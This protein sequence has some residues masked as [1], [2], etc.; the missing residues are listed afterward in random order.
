MTEIAPGTNRAFSFTVPT[1]HPDNVW[2]LWTTPD[3][4]EQWD[5]GLK[6]A[7]LDGPMSLGSV[8]RIVPHS[9]PTTTFKVVAYDLGQSYAFET[10][11]PGAILRVERAFNAERTEFT[12]R[13]TFSGATSVLFAALFGPGFRKALP[14]TMQQLKAI[15]E[16]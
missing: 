11:L 14:P 8:G 10:R 5:R 16:T 7:A 3:T 15:A 13:V 6:S 1:T 2:A 9:G 12:H 4:W